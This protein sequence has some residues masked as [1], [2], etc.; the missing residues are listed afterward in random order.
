M[1]TGT[2]RQLLE[3]G[4][5]SA[6]SVKQ[7][8]LRFDVSYEAAAR[9]FLALHP[10]LRALLIWQPPDKPNQPRTARCVACSKLGDTTVEFSR[11]SD[12]P[13]LVAEQAFET[14]RCVTSFE[15]VDVWVG[16]FDGQLVNIPLT[17]VESQGWG[18]P[19]QRHI[20]SF[21]AIPA[22]YGSQT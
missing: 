17:L 6:A 12:E 20:Y 13:R 19:P 18:T 7:L 22:H 3:Q 11:D 14:N 4:K 2:A 15:D 1:P 5:W 10:E 9:R 16:G 8:A 21:V